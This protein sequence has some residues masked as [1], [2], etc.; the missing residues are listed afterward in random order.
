[1]K[2]KKERIFYLDELRA[3][4]ILL[5]ILCHAAQF[6]PP[7]MD[8]S[9]LPVS[10]SYISVGRIGVPLFLMISGALLL[11][12]DYSLSSFFKRRFSRVII[13]VI[14]W[15][16]IAIIGFLIFFGWVLKDF[17]QFTEDYLKISWFIYTIIGLY[18]LMPI[19]NSFVKEHGPR[20]AGY[21][22][23]I[24]FCA[25]ILFSFDLRFEKTFYYLWDSVGTYIGYP[26][27]GYYLANKKF[28]VYSHAMIIFNTI[29][30]IACLLI[31]LNI[32]STEVILIQYL[33]PVLIIEC[34]ALF[35]IFRYISSYAHFNPKKAFAR[36]H[37]FIEKSWI[38]SL[39]YVIS[40]SSYLIFLTHTYIKNY[41]VYVF[42]IQTLDMIPVVFLIIS[43]LSIILGYIFVKIPRLYKL[44]GIN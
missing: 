37:K 23:L 31:N 2:S 12:K 34:A 3:L 42:P 6:F 40:I 30:F 21:F 44:T 19:Y 11:G 33:S 13:P 18:L 32:A 39:I 5:V 14:F 35:L 15:K 22:L 26:V 43:I 1:M 17:V 29:I 4:A 27:L 10:L 41:I 20:G 7:A 24:W 8:Y 16:I 25:M 36:F 9:S 38:G 28:K